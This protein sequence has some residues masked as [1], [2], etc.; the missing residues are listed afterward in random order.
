[1]V[2]PVDGHHRTLRML[3]SNIWG[4]QT[5]ELAGDLEMHGKVEYSVNSFCLVDVLA[6]PSKV[7]IWVSVAA[8]LLS[9][10]KYVQ[11]LP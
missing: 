10:G 5:E 3:V 11:K 6:G 7:H 1:M 4:G 2:S 9:I 8:I